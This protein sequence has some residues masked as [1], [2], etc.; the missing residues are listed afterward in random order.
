MLADSQQT[1]D[2]ARSNEHRYDFGIWLFSTLNICI[3]CQLHEG[4][5]MVSTT[6]LGVTS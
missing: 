4:A 5:R 3:K 6:L 1:G 2:K